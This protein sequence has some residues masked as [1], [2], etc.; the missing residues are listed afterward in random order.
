MQL[1]AL[2]FLSGYLAPFRLQIIIIFISIAIVSSAILGL[3]YALKHLIDQGFVNNNLNGLNDAFIL[4]LIMVALISLASYAR[5]LRVNWISEQLESNIR[6]SVYKN[7]I[8]I[9]PGYFDI[10]KVGDICSRLTTDL[11][12]VSN[13]IVMIASFSLRNSLM[14]IGGLILLLFTSLKLTS[15]VLLI[16]P[17]ILLPIIIIGRNTRKLSKKNQHSVAVCN[18]HLEESLSFIKAV[19]AYNREEFEYQQFVSL[20]DKSQEV[21]YKRIKLRS[22]L[23]ALVILLVLSAV[24]L[25][26]WVGGQDVLSGEMTAGAL[27]SF[28]F[29]AIL[30]ATSIGGLSEVYSDWQRASGALE[31]IMEIDRAEDSISEVKRPVKLKNDDQLNIDIQNI[32]FTYPSREESLV[33]D[34][35]SFNIKE[36]SIIALVGPSGAGK[37]TIFQLL[38]RFYDPDS[39]KILLGDVDIK[40][41][42]LKDLRNLFAFVSQ[43]AVIFSGTAYENILYGKIDAT[44]S[45]VEEAARLA[46][47]FEFFNS[48]PNGLNTHL[49]EKG[50]KLSGGQKQRIAIARA[51]L[52]NPK[53]LLLDEATSALDGENEKL[54]QLALNRLRKN[55]TTLVI[56]HRISTIAN[57]D[58]IIV[59]DKGKIV[60]QGKHDDLLRN[61]ELYQKLNKHSIK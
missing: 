13:T 52:C 11:T 57:A 40:K 38:L 18:S 7:I 44:K 41:L 28:I 31:R 42:L 24:A 22:L 61:N 53:I 2:K 51:I 10:Y 27:S 1:K 35:I 32:S 30:V 25:V 58:S 15:Y 17:V 36:G 20:T 16:L 33:L 48:M 46:E 21:A 49:G 50:V 6:K 55:R 60:A 59:L 4:L 39:G 26:L 43:D 34:D 56:A 12:L 37:S 19:Q 8:N 3:G 45:E 9:S 14:A 47:I 54:V 29:Y 23:F 5:S